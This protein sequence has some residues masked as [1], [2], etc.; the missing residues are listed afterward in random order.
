MRLYPQEGDA[1]PPPS[2]GQSEFSDNKDMLSF[3]GSFWGYLRLSTISIGNDYRWLGRIG[4]QTS[5]RRDCDHDRTP[6]RDHSTL[7]TRPQIEGI[8]TLFGGLVVIDDLAF[9]WG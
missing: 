1:P 6:G 7:E 9:D 4:N 5:D 2:P 3:W 8:A